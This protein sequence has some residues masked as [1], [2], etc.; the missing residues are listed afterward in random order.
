MLRLLLLI[1]AFVAAGL[2]SAQTPGENNPGPA[3]EA[4]P[5]SGPLA[6]EP[7]VPLGDVA[8]GSGNPSLAFVDPDKERADAVARGKKLFV[9]MNCAGCH[10]YDAKGGMGPDLTDHYWRYGGSPISIYESI[11]E[12]RPQGM[13][14]WSKAIPSQEVWNLVAYIETLG[15]AVSANDGP[16]QREGDRTG[17]LAAP[18]LSRP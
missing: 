13:P 15:G 1:S 10:G 11:V 4:D 7:R 5:S 6:N 9:Q 3:E 2:A 17:E 16:A 8:G 12:G 14:S 18:E